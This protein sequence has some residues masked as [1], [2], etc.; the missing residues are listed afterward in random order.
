MFHSKLTAKSVE[1]EAVQKASLIPCK[2]V[3]KISDLPQIDPSKTLLKVKKI[4]GHPS[5]LG[6]SI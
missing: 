3:V 5:E 6:L 2:T 1:Y 4:R